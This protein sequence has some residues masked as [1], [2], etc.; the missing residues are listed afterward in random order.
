MKEILLFPALVWLI[1]ALVV[2]RTMPNERPPVDPR[3]EERGHAY[4]RNV[5]H[6]PHL[7]DGRPAEPEVRW[8][9]RRSPFAYGR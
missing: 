8:R 2:V 6:W 7:A 1:I 9:C 5:G 3:C 4:H